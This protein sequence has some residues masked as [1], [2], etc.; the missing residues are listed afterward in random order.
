MIELKACVT[1]QSWVNR[2]YRW[3][4]S[5][6]PCGAPVLRISDVEVLFPTFTTRGPARQKVQDP[7][8]QG[9]VQTQGPKLKDEL[10]EYYGVEC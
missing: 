3:G 7:F 6:H 10:G 9:R 1:T 8:A 5:M 2:E 4:L